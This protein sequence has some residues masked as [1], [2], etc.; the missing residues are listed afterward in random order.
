MPKTLPAALS[1]HL[2][3]DVTTLAVCWRITREDG[4]VFRFTDHDEDVTF[5]DG[6]GL[7]VVVQAGETY[8][9]IGA[10]SRTA[11]AVKTGLRVDNLDL[12]GLISEDGTDGGIL[13]QDL[14]TRKF[15]NAQVEIFMV[16]WTAPDDGAIPIMRGHLGEIKLNADT[17]TYEAEMRGLS[18]KYAQ[19]V[20]EL[21][22]FKCRADLFDERCGLDAADFTQRAAVES[23]VSRREFVVPATQ[24]LTSPTPSLD[25][26]VRHGAVV[27]PV[28]TLRLKRGPLQLGTRDAPFLLSTPAELDTIRDNPQ[29]W[30]ALVNDIDMSA[31][32]FWTPVPEFRG[33][34]DGRGFEIQN[35][36]VDRPGNAVADGHAAFIDQLL[37][38]ATVRR[39][40]I[41][42]GT[43]QSGDD[44]SFFT[45][46]LAA[47]TNAT[48]QTNLFGGVEDCYAVGCDVVS[49]T[50]LTPNRLSGMVGK[51][52][53]FLFFRRC[54]AACNLVALGATGSWSDRVGNVL[55]ETGVGIG[56]VAQVL[57]DIYTDEERQIVDQFGE[58][59]DSAE[60]NQLTT[61]ESRD[62][63]NLEGLDFDVVWRKPELITAA[64][65]VDT[66]GET[67]TFNENSPAQDTLVRSAGSWITDGFEPGDRV[68]VS[69]TSS[70]ITTLP[71]ATTNISFANVDPDTINRSTGSWITEGYVPGLL[72]TVTGADILS[73]NG[74]YLVIGVTATALTL[75][76]GHKLTTDSTNAGVTVSTLGNDGFKD[77]LSVTATT[78][79]L[80]RNHGFIQQGPIAGSGVTIGADKY[81]QLLPVRAP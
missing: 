1:T 12:T 67:L 14:Q 49:D 56:E 3:G 19:K 80:S 68:S 27:D 31:F 75:A 43:F 47:R 29:A 18:Q 39:L 10:F 64:A 41:R 63:D 34:L 74:T 69:G 35:L 46:P 16:N 21:Y 50:V 13:L 54:F 59:E 52:D 48:P 36:D 26:G 77:V 33:G 32:G 30:Y 42:G 65:Y 11:I 66:G 51:I 9:A 38:G 24:S 60:V 37:Q 45:A 70:S 20:G 25:S 53:D 73:N 76:P 7:T 62:S 23:V 8:Q 79:T 28:G 55:S 78:L 6:F 2:T 22:T 40:G 72:I 57:D 61:A 71:A 15:T 81:P 17:K 44:T 4:E 58:G 5:D